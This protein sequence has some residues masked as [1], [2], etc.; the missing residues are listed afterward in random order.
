MSVTTD[1][2]KTGDTITGRFTL[3]NLPTLSLDEVKK[4]AFAVAG[5]AD[6]AIEQVKDVPADVQSQVAKAQARLAE[7]PTVVK[8]LPTQVKGL[9]GEVET[10]VA[11]ATEQADR[12]LRRPRRPR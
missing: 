5:L 7:V 1:V 8:T 12:P 4:P 11:K 9:R 3:K 6:L 2:T 10:R